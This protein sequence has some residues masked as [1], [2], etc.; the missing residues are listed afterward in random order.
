MGLPDVETLINNHDAKEGAGTDT[1]P[2]TQSTESKETAPET[3]GNASDILELDK[4][5]KFKFEGKEYT[6]KELKAAYMRQEDYTRKTQEL[7]QERKY[8]DNLQADL[9]S[10]RANPALVD[11]F[12]EIYPEKF[13][14][15]VDMILA[16]DEQAKEAGKQPTDTNQ[17]VNPEIEARIN[18]IEQS[19]FA[20]EV[21][22]IEAT[23]SSYDSKFSAKYPMANV[24]D[25]YAKASLLNQKGEKLSE[26]S[27][28]KLWKSSHDSDKARFETFYK[29]QI[30]EQKQA[31]SKAKDTQTGG[32]IPGQAP[33]NLKLKD[34]RN[35]MMKD[36]GR[37]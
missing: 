33:Q 12:K 25:V 37:G 28:D 30:K 10:I 2:D 34:V 16:K 35:Q 18:R 26:E 36:M 32:G 29:N 3:G 8:I 6:Q 4:I 20:K 1:A 15:Y 5:E 24:N 17:V 13:H 31:A 7:A 9:S 19:F 14:G 27:W 23:L 11:K 22:A 21:E